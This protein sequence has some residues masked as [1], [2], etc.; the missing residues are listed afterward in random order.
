MDWLIVRLPWK[1]INTITIIE[2]T[3]INIKCAHIVNNLDEFDFPLD[4]FYFVLRIHLSF[5]YQASSKWKLYLHTRTDENCR[6]PDHNLL[7]MKTILAHQDW[8]K[9]QKTRPLVGVAQRAPPPTT[10]ISSGSYPEF[11]SLPTTTICRL[12]TL[13]NFL[14]LAPSWGRATVCYSWLFWDLLICRFSAGSRTRSAVHSS[15]NTTEEKVPRLCYCFALFAANKSLDLN[16]D[17]FCIF[18]L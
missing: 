16:K 9:W 12:H 11:H 13:L 2:R 15:H 4:S 3:I 1:G 14:F 17:G 7:Q 6:R 8:R 18:R 5:S 10:G